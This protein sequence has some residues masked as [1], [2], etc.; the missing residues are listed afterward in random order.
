MSSKNLNV[1][2]RKLLH[3]FNRFYFERGEI[4]KKTPGFHLW[5]DFCNGFFCCINWNG[6]YYYITFRDNCLKIRSKRYIQFFSN[7]YFAAFSPDSNIVASFFKKTG[8][9]LP[10]LPG[11][12]KYKNFHFF[13]IIFS[14][15]R[16]Q[17]PGFR[18]ATGWAY[19]IVMIF[20]SCLFGFGVR[21]QACRAS[22]TVFFISSTGGSTPVQSL[23]ASAP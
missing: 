16:N 20:C 5:G 18:L 11:S 12:P 15:I 23:K 4:H 1:P 14:K 8:E 7:L 13:G 21:I 19:G 2:W 6:Y 10:H 17:R 22:S 3:S 9:P